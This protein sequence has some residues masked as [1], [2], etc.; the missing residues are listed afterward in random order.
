VSVPPIVVPLL[1]PPFI[2]F[3]VSVG[4]LIV[5]VSVVGGAAVVVVVESAVELFVLL[6]EQ[7]II[8]I[9]ITAENII[10]FIQLNFKLKIFI[11]LP[12]LFCHTTIFLF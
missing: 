5:E 10:F 2:V 3:I 11:L 1:V 9:A 8:A 4:V 7:L 6:L 12:Q